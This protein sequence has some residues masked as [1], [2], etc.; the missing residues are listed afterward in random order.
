MQEDLRLEKTL[1]TARDILY[2]KLPDDVKHSCP[3]LIVMNDMIEMI[4]TENSSR[5]ADELGINVIS[6]ACPRSG[7]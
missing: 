2:K 3:A 7:K 5:I 6:L 1:E 4:K